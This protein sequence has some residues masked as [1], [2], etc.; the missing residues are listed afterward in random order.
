MH[1]AINAH[2]LHTGSSYRGAGVSNYSRRL[3]L[4][5]GEI[6]AQEGTAVRLTAFTHAPDFAPSGIQIRA[7]RLPLHR[8][9]LRI[10]WEQ[11]V[12][13]WQLRRID[14]DLVHGLVNV[15][16]AAGSTPGI[17][18][19]HDL[20]FMR[21]PE[22]LPRAKR[23][24][25]AKAC[26]AGVRKA[27]KVIAVSRQTADDL[28]HYY[29]TDAAKIE[30]IYN[31]VGAEY[32]PG[33]AKAV[34]EFRAQRGLPAQYILYV[35]TLE[36]R[37]NL[38][39]LVRVFARWRAQTP[40]AA[41]CKLLLAGARGWGYQSLFDEVERLGLHN[42]VLFP[43]FVPAGELPDWYR[44][45]TLFVYPSLF[46]GFG[47]PVVEAMACG[48]AVLCGNSPSLLEVAG[49]AASIVAADD[50]DA[51][52]TA[53]SRLMASQELREELQSR[54]SAQAAKFRW[55]AA[56]QETLALYAQALA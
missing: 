51:L 45:A 25:L 49:D 47:L 39:R 3:L 1:V 40:A 12:L 54:G 8:P 33:D 21:M 28:M 16:P 23:A 15:L 24:Y 29:Q 36:P 7:S 52:Y 19:V 38:D 18:T 43:G 56:A 10:A 22:K 35:G 11:S 30:V 13:P 55:T 44:A 2:L 46:E 14:A 42:A 53:L 4:R 32:V 27:R 6:V 41:E 20:S 48:T 26:A 17:V 9:L 37:K 31:G 34:A 5:R 50:E